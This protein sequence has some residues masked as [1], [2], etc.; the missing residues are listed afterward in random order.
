VNVIYPPEA[1]GW[2]RRVTLFPFVAGV[3]LVAM[4]ARV[5]ALA[6]VTLAWGP[7]T[8]TNVVGY[9][10]YYGTASSTY[11]NKLSV[12]DTTSAT[13]TGLIPGTT[14]YFAATAYNASGVESPFSNQASYAVPTLLAPT[15]NAISD[16][17]VDENSGY[18]TVNLSGISAGGAANQISTLNFSV[19]SS[20]PSVISDAFVTYANGSSTGVLYFMPAHDAYGTAVISVTATNNQSEN[21]L[22]TQLFTVTVTPVNQPPTINPITPF[23]LTENAGALTVKLS[24]ITSGAPNE[25]QTLTVT[26]TSSNHGLIPDPL[27]N[28]T[29]PNTT[30]TLTFTPMSGA[31]GTDTITVSVN[32][33]G[34]SNNI[35]NTSFQVTL[36][37]SGS[38]P[39]TIAASTVL[40]PAAAVN[41]QPAWN[42]LG[43]SGYN[44]VV[45]ASTNLVDWV[46]V[47]TNTPPFVFVDP[48]A[49]QYSQRFYRSV[50]AP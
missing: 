21:N 22:V 33:G 27:V 11:T 42:V 40:T 2:L 44:Y 24:G 41:G 50:Y 47:Q 15:L 30:G 17:S 25:S 46:P 3:C 4:Q 31:V 8:D 37:G 18:Q 29:S 39:N 1:F 35:V 6:S 9:N 12:G 7:S 23:F 49:G 14:Y 5:F 43:V 28:Y 32:D 45:E 16:V 19:V 10:V 13:I 36:L 38:D 26:A 48:D 34:T 20:D